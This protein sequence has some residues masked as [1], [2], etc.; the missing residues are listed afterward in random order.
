MPY[1]LLTDSALLYFAFLMLTEHRTYPL[2]ER[3]RIVFG[4]M[5]AV[6]AGV[7]QLTGLFGSVTVGLVIADM[8]V[9][10][11]NKVTVKT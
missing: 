9:P 5:A 3:G 10:W 6:F 7:F 1:A 2:M 8:F 11:L 4:A